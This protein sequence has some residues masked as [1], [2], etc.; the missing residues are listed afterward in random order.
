MALSNSC[1]LCYQNSSTFELTITS[2]L[3]NFKEI[4]RLCTNYDEKNQG[5]CIPI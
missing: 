2:G 1:D 3:K 4:E 5:F